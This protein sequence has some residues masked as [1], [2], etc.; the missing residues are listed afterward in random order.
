MKT[1]YLPDYYQHHVISEQQQSQPDMMS[2][3]AGTMLSTLLGAESIVCTG[4][5]GNRHYQEL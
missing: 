3:K 5:H 4:E 1:N 2:A